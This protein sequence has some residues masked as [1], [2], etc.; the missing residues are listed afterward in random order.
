MLK[1]QQDKIKIQQDNIDLA[2][3]KESTTTLFTDKILQQLNTVSEEDSKVIR[4]TIILELMRLDIQ[5]HLLSRTGQ[6]Q[7]DKLGEL[8]RDCN[9]IPFRIALFTGNYDALNA[10]EETK[11]VNYAF[12][13]DNRIARH[14]ALHALG[15]KA[16]GHSSA[17]GSSLPSL[18]S[19]GPATAGLLSSR[20][21]EIL[22]LSDNLES[23]D[24]AIDALDAISRLAER[25]RDISSDLKK[26]GTPDLIRGKMLDLKKRLTNLQASNKRNEQQKQKELQEQLTHL[27]ST[28]KTEQLKQKELQEQLDHLESTWKSLVSSGFCSDDDRQLATGSPQTRQSL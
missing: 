7:E 3:K 18:A 25:F 6:D 1:N 10:S 17:P 26:T 22:M 27:D 16:L 19:E 2:L 20:L 12:N 21:E 28:W 15:S 11:W 8:E 13:T 5:A 23:R 9:D 24:L 14:T 4:G